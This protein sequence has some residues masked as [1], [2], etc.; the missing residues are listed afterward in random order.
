MTRGTKCFLQDNN[1]TTPLCLACGQG[2]EDVV[3][4]LLVLS[5][6][7]SENVNASSLVWGTPLY[8]AAWKEH[9][10]IIKQLLDHGA[11]IDSVRPGNLLGSALMAAC[12]ESRN[13]VVQT[14]LSRG[15]SL[16][17][18]GSRFQSAEGTARAFRKENIL[19]ILEEHEKNPKRDSRK[20]PIDRGIMGSDDHEKLSAE[21]TKHNNK[22]GEDAGQQIELPVTVSVQPASAGPTRERF[23]ED[24]ILES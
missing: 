3:Q 7:V 18:E 2:L 9:D 13:A 16:E 5:T 1:S 22:R 14:L 12:A 23:Q 20:G 11:I 19:K 8:H 10:S 17:V 21:E 24:E 4:R 15:A 6:G